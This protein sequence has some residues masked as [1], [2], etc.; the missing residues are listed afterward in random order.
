[1]FCVDKLSVGYHKEEQTI[2]L[3][4]EVDVI[5]KPGEL[6]CLLGS[7]GCGKSTLLKTLAGLHPPLN[8]SNESINSL[9]Q[10]NNLALVLTEKIVSTSATVWDLISTAR[11]PH[12]NWRITFQEKDLQAIQFAIARVGLNNIQDR[13][14]HEISDGQLQLTLIARAL[15]QETSFIF[16]D[17]PTAHLDLNNRMDV[18]LLLRSLAHQFGKTILVSTHELDLALQLADRLWVVYNK[19]IENGLPEDLVLSGLLD[20]AFP[21]KGFDL[22]TGEMKYEPTKNIHIELKGE[23]YRYL[24]TKN[25]L[26]RTGYTITEFSPRFS[27]IISDDKWLIGDNSF[28]TLHSI[29]HFIE[30]EIIRS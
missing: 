27:I 28:T 20:Q 21:R 8:G 23:G 16:L 14:I 24:W 17:E 25:A 3:L 7:N 2:L 13:F 9:H 22:K 1:M 26:Q 10:S 6:I 18:M 11:Y 29:L 12:L 4:N 15:A 5:L 19:K 30:Q